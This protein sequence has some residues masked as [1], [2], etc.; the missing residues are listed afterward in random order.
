MFVSPRHLM[1]RLDADTRLFK[2]RLVDQVAKAVDSDI[3]L[4]LLMFISLILS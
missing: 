3:F 4:G 1:K 2:G